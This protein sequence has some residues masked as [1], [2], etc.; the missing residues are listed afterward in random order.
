MNSPLRTT[1][2]CLPVVLMVA[3]LASSFARSVSAA[4]YDH[5]RTGK[6][7]LGVNVGGGVGFAVGDMKSI[8]ETDT[9]WGL[10][11][12]FRLAGALRP[13]LFM[14]VELGG[15][16]AEISTNADFTTYV[17]GPSV[18]YYPKEGGSFIRGTLGLGRVQWTVPS[19][20]ITTTA[21]KGGGFG[22]LIA[23]G[24]E[25]RMSSSMAIGGQ[26]D[27][28]YANAGEIPELTALY[29]EFSAQA[30]WLNFTVV[31]DFSL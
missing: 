24:Y 3:V 26:L 12:N 31:F 9:K 13:D 21:I 4:D 25:W 17:I 5:F 10:G 8:A 28:G 29:G 20:G 19:G 7:L 22:V 6:M 23:G 2:Q 18:S 27:F 30:M 14:G 11:Y 15:W 16:T 1:R